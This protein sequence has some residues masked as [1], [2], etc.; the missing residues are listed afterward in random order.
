MIVAN[1]AANIIY[2]FSNAVLIQVQFGCVWYIRIGLDWLSFL[3]LLMIL[4]HIINLQL[5]Y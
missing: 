1:L 2:A 3:A 4:I 5:V